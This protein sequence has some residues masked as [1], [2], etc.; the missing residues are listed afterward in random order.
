MD[1]WPSRGTKLLITKCKCVCV[2]TWTG[3][4]VAQCL[5]GVEPQADVPS[6]SR[7]GV[8]AGSRPHVVSPSARH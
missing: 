3:L 1:W 5:L 2:C 4:C 8:A 6:V 7:W